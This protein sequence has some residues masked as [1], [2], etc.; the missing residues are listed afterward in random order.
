[1]HTRVY[2]E[3]LAGKG[4]GIDDARPSIE[5]VHRIRTAPISRRLDDVHPFLIGIK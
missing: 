1:L 4:F 2:Q 3:T 5:L